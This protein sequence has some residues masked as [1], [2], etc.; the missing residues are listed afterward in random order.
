ML[1][2]CSCR[3]QVSPYKEWLHFIY[4]TFL[5]FLLSARLVL[6]TVRSRKLNA[7]KEFIVV[8]VGRYA[9][10]I[11]NLNREWVEG[12]VKGRLSLE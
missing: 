8:E 6:D 12:S 4:Q 5:E 11:C 3:C 2:S 10:A 7:H 1:L 9:N